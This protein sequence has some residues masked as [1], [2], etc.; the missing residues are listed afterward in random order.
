[1]AVY[2]LITNASSAGVIPSPTL[3]PQQAQPGSQMVTPEGP[4]N[5]NMPTQGQWFQMI[6]SAKSDNLAAT[7]IVV[8]SNNGSDWSDIGVTLTAT[9]AAYSVQSKAANIPAKHF[10]AYLSTLTGTG[11][12]AGVLM[13][14]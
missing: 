6:A 10:A 11:A 14:A 12:V 2:N 9:G 4:N 3:A 8:A 7:A 5:P 13:S 1:M